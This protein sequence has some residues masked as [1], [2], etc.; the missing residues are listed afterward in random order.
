MKNKNNS[1]I[2]FYVLSFVGLL[3]FMIGFALGINGLLI[4]Y[5]QKAFTLSSSSSYLV[6]TSTFG[7]FVLFG[8]PSGVLIRAIGYKKSMIVSFSFFA[9][10]LALF[11]P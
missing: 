7:A 5:L 3:F 8:Y 11:I 10:G 4:P 2:Y 6:L 1:S 9:I